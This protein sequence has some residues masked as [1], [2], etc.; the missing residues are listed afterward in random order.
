MPVNEVTATNATLEALACGTPIISNRIG[1]MPDYVDDACGWLFDKGEVD[2]VVNLIGDMCRDPHMAS[3]SP[4]RR[5]IQ[6]ARFQLAA[7]CKQ[8]SDPL[9][10]CSTWSLSECR[11]CRMGLIAT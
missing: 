10:R 3:S 11:T 6:R 4:A 8:D 7:C 5:P 2:R 9:R 1:G